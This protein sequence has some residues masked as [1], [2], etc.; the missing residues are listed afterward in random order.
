VAGDHAALCGLT[1][2]GL[3]GVDIPR[4]L[5]R[6][7]RVWVRV[8]SGQHWPNRPELC[9]VRAAQ[10]A[11]TRLI[12]HMLVV[13]PAWCWVQ[14]GAWATLDEM[15]E[16]AD[17]LMRRHRPVTT[18]D[19]LRDTVS[20][21]GRVKGVRLARAALELARPGT[22]STPET[23]V[24]LLLVRSGLPTPVVNLPIR[25]RTGQIL[26]LLDLAYEEQK[27][28]AE[29]DG[30]YHVQSQAQMSADL[31]RRRY[32]EDLGWRLITV[33]AADLA[34]APGS[35]VA[36]VRAALASRS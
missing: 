9:L 24:R 3:M 13:D 11:P 5:A 2:L 34:H 36:S 31:T 23:D 21:A 8:P 27:V 35:I 10:S 20:S 7:E 17:A 16:M 6:D 12:D 4:R 18:L 33:S 30:L 22:D 19:H 15:V 25:D 1:A 28:A 26:Y 29:Y 32:L 14:M